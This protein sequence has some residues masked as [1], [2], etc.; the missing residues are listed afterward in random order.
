[1]ILS[2]ADLADLEAAKRFLNIPALAAKISETVGTPSRYGR[3]RRS[4]VAPRW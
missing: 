2:D 4:E 3:C 1:M